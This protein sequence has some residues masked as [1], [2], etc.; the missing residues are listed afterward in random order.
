MKSSSELIHLRS[1]TASL[2]P[3]SASA[4]RK[5]PQFLAGTPQF[6]EVPSVS[7]GAMLCRRFRTPVARFPTKRRASVNW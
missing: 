6:C 2:I 5:T 1:A 4:R 3:D 7:P